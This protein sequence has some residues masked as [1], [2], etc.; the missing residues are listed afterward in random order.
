MLP[1]IIVEKHAS[2]VHLVVTVAGNEHVW[3]F[4]QPD[5]H[6]VHMDQLAQEIAEAVHAPGYI[7][8]T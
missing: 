6:P 2:A 7:T 4:T 8:K 3:F 1:R 5:R